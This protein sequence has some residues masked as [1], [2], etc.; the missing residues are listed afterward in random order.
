MDKPLGPTWKGDWI[1]YLNEMYE[2]HYPCLDHKDC[3]ELA[4][5]LLEKDQKIAELES[6][7]ID[8]IVSDLAN[9]ISE[10]E[11]EFLLNS[12]FRHIEKHDVADQIFGSDEDLKEFIRVY[13][14][15][16]IKNFGRTYYGY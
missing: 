15:F 2:Q 12:L 14:K 5:L 4:D 10:D 13:K 9:Y 3:K 7:K 16:M 6:S 1:P 11:K 8:P